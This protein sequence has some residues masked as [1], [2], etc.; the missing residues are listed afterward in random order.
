MKNLKIYKYVKNKQ[1]IIEQSVGYRG[2]QCKILKII[3]RNE[4]GIT[5]YQMQQKAVLRRNFRVIY[6]YIKKNERSQI[7]NLTLNLQ[8]AT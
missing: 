8:E 3:D 1:H 5:T 6:S 4:N 7:N 2:N